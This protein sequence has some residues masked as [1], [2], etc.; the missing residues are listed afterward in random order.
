[1]VND[2][3]DTTEMYLKTVFEL[4]E[5]G[6][7]ALR[8]RIV[9]RLDQS[10]PTVSETVGR[11]ERAG[12]LVVGPDREIRFTPEGC[13]RAAHV[14]RR[15][16]LAECLLLEVIGLELEKIHDEACR[17]EHALSDEAAERISAL[18]NAPKQDPFGNPIPAETCC[19]L[20]GESALPGN[21]P[22]PMIISAAAAGL[23]P[24]VDVTPGPEI[25]RLMRIAEVLQADGEL[26]AELRP[27]GLVPGVQVQVVAREQQVL[28][29]AVLADDA[30]ATD[31][32]DMD[33]GAATDTPDTVAVPEYVA[34]ALFVAM[35]P[36]R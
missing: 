36:Q 19:Q 28:Q 34:Q 14:M 21:E 2:L 4:K 18:L 6:I 22:E 30:A 8:A 15:H 5:E 12:L 35:V 20:S 25:W 11:L 13:R 23:T 9:E 24:L 27:V 26:L 33:G 31:T 29:I 32:P 7:P 1:M 17:W 16:R 10:G 3:L